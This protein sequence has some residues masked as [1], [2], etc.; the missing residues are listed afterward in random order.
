MR[1]VCIIQ[2]R[3]GS[4]RLPGK[5]MRE[6]CDTPMLELLIERLKHARRLD[7]I[8]VATTD[9]PADDVL[10]ALASRLDVGCFR[11]SEDDVLD[12]VLK[13]AQA[14]KADVIVE[15]TGDCPLTDPAMVDR[16]TDVYLANRYDFVGNRAARIRPTY[17]NG[18]GIRI[19]S[20]AVLAEVDRLTQDPADREHVS[21]YIW[22]HPER[23]T[24]HTADSDLPERHW[25]HRLT[26]DTIEDLEV[27]R[28]IFEELH[29]KNPAFGIGEVLEVLER[30]P[31]LLEINKDVKQKPA[32]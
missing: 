12:R 26:V 13:A 21:I 22:E 31:E 14:A 16:V 11:G 17:P 10:E 2:A 20:T 15:I 1:V 23:F 4:N 3:M 29:P 24:L 8:V 5:V 25:D 27:I 19:F 28:A 6:I 32:R 30:R 9:K 7:A 18:F